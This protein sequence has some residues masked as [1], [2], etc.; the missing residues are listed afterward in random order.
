MKRSMKDM[1]KELSAIGE[2]LAEVKVYADRW[3]SAASADD[4]AENGEDLC[5]AW[6]NYMRIRGGR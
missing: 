5:I 3:D 2:V 1:K 4:L 6:D